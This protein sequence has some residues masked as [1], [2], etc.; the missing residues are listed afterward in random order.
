M[1]FITALFRWLQAVPLPALNDVYELAGVLLV[2]IHRG[3]PISCLT[4]LFP[5]LPCDSGRMHM[6]GHSSW[7]RPITIG[8]AT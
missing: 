4:D 1:R 3:N 8:L 6:T 7:C 5:P 2:V